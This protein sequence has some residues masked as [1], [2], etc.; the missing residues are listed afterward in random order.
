MDGETRSAG[1]IG[2]DGSD[3]RFGRLLWQGRPAVEIRPAPGE[4]GLR[5]AF[6][7]YLIGTHLEAAGIPVPEIFHFDRKTGVLVVE[8]L[9]DERLYEFGRRCRRSGQTKEL[10]ERYKQV[11]DILVAMQTRGAEG[12]RTDWCWQGGH[13]DRSLCLQREAGYFLDSFIKAYLEVQVDGTLE[14]RFMAEA[15]WVCAQ[16]ADGDLFLHRD[17]QSRNIMLKGGRHPYII[18]FQAARLGPAG[19]DPA[20]L[21]H[22]PY[23]DLPWHVRQELLDYYMERFYKEASGRSPAGAK[24]KR[25]EEFERTFWYLSLMR[26]LQAAG[27][28]GFLAG[29]KGRSFFKDHMVSAVKGLLAVLSRP[30]LAGLSA[31]PALAGMAA[32]RLQENI[33][34]SGL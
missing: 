21:I 6:S 20:S 16:A 33:E 11:L 27:A 17:F 34:Q 5:E 3:R 30:E 4:D 8:D 18:D 14:E 31:V 22:D 29:V 23:A 28:Y 26:L 7:F 24:G 13:Y 12:F 10:L 19:Y 32:A 25:P 15:A 1:G 2:P 9:G